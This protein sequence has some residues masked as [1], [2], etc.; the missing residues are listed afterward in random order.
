MLKPILPAIMA[1]AML[2][3]WPAAA[4]DY[5][6][7]RCAAA[8][9]YVGPALEPAPSGEAL[10]SAAPANGSFDTATGARLD[11][12]LATALAATKASAMTVAVSIPGGA[13]WSAVRTANG[14]PAPQRFWWASAGKMLTAST[15]LQLAEEG[16]LSLQDPV[17]RYVSGVPN[18]EAITLEHLLAHTSGLFSA[19]EDRRVREG[20]VR[21][22]LAEELA[23]LRRHGAMFCPGER[24]R[25]SN[26]GYGLLGAVIEKVDGRPFGKAA[27]TRVLDVMGAGSLRILN[28]GEEAAD[29]AP[30]APAAPDAVLVQPSRAGPAAPLVGL[31]EDM[32]RLLQATLSTGSLAGRTRNLRL[33]KLY[34]MFDPGSFYGL[35]IMVY[36]PPGTGHYWIGHSGGSPGAN[37]I[38]IWSPADGA[39]VSVAMTGDGSAAATANL[40]LAALGG[41]AKATKR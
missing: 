2:L 33:A 25:Y 29:V 13:S 22:T 28:A 38:S 17:A 37:A 12:A 4:G 9:P 40:L 39:F 26:S 31:A 30:L 8:K 19:N 18:G 36:R 3:A 5:K 16:R 35:G 21:L 1:G 14:S 24:W 32:N 23:V 15:V 34:Q 20:R 10:P 7:V 27:T 41:E 11:T 6:P